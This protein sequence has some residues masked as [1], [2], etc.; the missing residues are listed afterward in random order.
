MTSFP[1]NAWRYHMRIPIRGLER[2]NLPDCLEHEELAMWQFIS[3]E[4]AYAQIQAGEWQ[5]EASFMEPYQAFAKDLAVISLY[6]FKIIRGIEVAERFVSETVSDD[7]RAWKVIARQGEWVKVPLIV[8]QD[9]G[10][11]FHVDPDQEDLEVIRARWAT[12]PLWFQDG[13]RRKHPTLR[14]L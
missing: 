14:A 1:V 4:D 3:R 8:T 2:Q 6:L 11:R 12:Y 5:M 9:E 10:R 7:A 13:M